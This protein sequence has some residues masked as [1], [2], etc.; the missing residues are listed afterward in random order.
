MRS[1]NTASAAGTVFAQLLD[2][3]AASLA[4]ENA[5]A[6][7]VPSDELHQEILLPL[8]PAL[9]GDNAI[10]SHWETNKSTG[11]F[12]RLQSHL[13][14]DAPRPHWT[15]EDFAIHVTASYSAS[16]DA[17]ALADTLLSEESLRDLAA[18]LMNKVLG[19]IW[20]ELP[21]PSAARA[22]LVASDEAQETDEVVSLARVVDVGSSREPLL[23]E[24]KKPAEM[25]RAFSFVAPINSR[26]LARPQ[27]W[28]SRR[29]PLAGARTPI[30]LTLL[31]SFPENPLDPR[32][33]LS[34]S[35]TR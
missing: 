5:S 28:N 29:N 26:L 21:L 10:R 11:F 35:R 25:V 23:E 1:D 19:S 7:D 6:F 18:S 33:D 32:F 24:A 12:A 14:H 3:T 15:A 13:D 8:L 31:P 9:L 16:P 2:R 4:P 22:P 30:P 17:R 34:A 20:P 27:P